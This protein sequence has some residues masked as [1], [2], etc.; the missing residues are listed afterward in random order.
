MS[1]QGSLRE[2]IQADR[3]ANTVEECKYKRDYGDII[4]RTPDVC[5]LMY[6]YV[7]I[8]L[9]HVLSPFTEV[10]ISVWQKYV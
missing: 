5:C 7:S 10:L 3:V 4:W 8:S 6:H 2:T 9:N 1:D